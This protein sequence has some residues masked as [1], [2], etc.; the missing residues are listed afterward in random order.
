[1][2]NSRSL[3]RYSYVQGNPVSLTDPFGL[4]PDGNGTAE[5]FMQQ[6]SSIIGLI[7][8]TEGGTD[9]SGLGHTALDLIGIVWDGADIINA[10][11]YG[12]E[13]NYA[14]ATVSAI[15]ALPFVGTLAGGS[16]GLALK[17]IGHSLTFGMA[18]QGT[19]EAA[20]RAVEAYQN[21]T[22]SGWNFL[23][24]GLNALGMGLSGRAAFSEGRKLANRIAASEA[25]QRAAKGIVKSESNS[26][27]DLTIMSRNSSKGN[28]NAISHFDVELNARQ[29]KLLQQ[30]PDYDS[31]IVVKKSDVNMKRAQEL[32][33]AGYRWSGHTH[34]RIGYNVRISSSGDQ[35]ILKIFNQTQSAIYDSSGKFDLFGGS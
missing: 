13:G 34:P 3:N 27:A 16:A 9:W 12:L 33:I 25:G 20:G 6:A 17:V 7:G 30:L 2:G 28:P 24:V 14:M 19:W 1:M 4:C 29:K 23:D 21:G 32:V 8:E 26:N 15:C 35:N 31:F 18:A 5:G 10:V 22:L 11:W